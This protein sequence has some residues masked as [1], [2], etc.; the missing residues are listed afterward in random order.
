MS[1]QA[2][3]NSPPTANSCGTPE[4]RLAGTLASV[5]ERPTPSPLAWVQ[6]SALRGRADV[7]HGGGVVPQPGNGGAPHRAGNVDVVHGFERGHAIAYE[8]RPHARTPAGGGEPG[9]CQPLAARRQADAIGRAACDPPTLA[10]QRDGRRPALGSAAT[11]LKVTDLVA[12]ATPVGHPQVAPCARQRRPAAGADVPIDD[13]LG[14]SSAIAVDVRRAQREAVA[15]IVGAAVQPDHGG[16]VIQ[17]GDGGKAMLGRPDIGVWR[18]PG[19]PAPAIVAGTSH[20]DAVVIGAVGPRMAHQPVRQPEI[21]GD[22]Y[23][24]GE[25]APVDEPVPASGHLYR[26]FETAVPIARRTQHMPAVRCRFDPGQ[27]R[28]TGGMGGE[29][30]QACAR[31]R[32]RRYGLNAGGDRGGR[33]AQ[34]PQEGGHGEQQRRRGGDGPAASTQ[35]LPCHDSST[36]RGSPSRNCEPLLP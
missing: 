22:R 25:V 23:H 1:V 8:G 33:V 11:Q 7:Q 6:R 13:G 20:G 12:G 31:T 28:A 19:R 36:A 30:R 27:H 5:R 9:R 15:G 18:R 3:S 17:S 35:K 4:S 24:G 2:I 14:A 21:G 26:R 10:G 16:P 32:R 29:P 34:P